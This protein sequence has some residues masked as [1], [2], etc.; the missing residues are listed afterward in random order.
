MS[1]VWLENR[2][3]PWC[4]REDSPSLAS[5]GRAFVINMDD[6]SGGGTHWTAAKFFPREGVL[7]YADPFGTV[8]NGHPPKELAELANKIVA[9]RVAWQRPDTNY[10]GYYAHIF[11]KALEKMKPSNNEKDLENTIRESIT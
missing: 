3:T 9:N 7:F 4:F 6:K 8:M 1:N 10:C 2:G 5:K 11:T